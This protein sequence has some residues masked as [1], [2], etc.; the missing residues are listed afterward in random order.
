MFGLHDSDILL[1]LLFSTFIKINQTPSTAEG[2]Q[3]PGV[4]Q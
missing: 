3:T 1:H 2:G 4:S